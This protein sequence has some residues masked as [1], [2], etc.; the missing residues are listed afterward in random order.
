MPKEEYNI[1]LF[2]YILVQLS[3][4]WWGRDGMPEVVQI[5]TARPLFFGR[6]ERGT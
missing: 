3:H 5:D 4:D 6:Q 1:I 2:A